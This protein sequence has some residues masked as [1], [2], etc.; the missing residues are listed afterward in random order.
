[1]RADSPR[2]K[3][4]ESG[5]S[6]TNAGKEFKATSFAGKKLFLNKFKEHS[7]CL[8]LREWEDPVLELPGVRYVEAGMSTKLLTT[9]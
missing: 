9:L 2:L 4:A 3:D 8:N 5:A 1:M 6:A 7:N